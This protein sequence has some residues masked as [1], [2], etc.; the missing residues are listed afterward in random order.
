MD[1]SIL[2]IFNKADFNT[3]MLALAITGWILNH[4]Y[5][6]SIWFLGGAILCSI[7]CMI[8]LCVFIYKWVIAKRHIKKDEKY[9][10]EIREKNAQNQRLQAQYAYDRLSMEGKLLLSEIVRIG[11]KS[12]YSDVYIIRNKLEHYSLVSQLYHLRYSDNVIASWISVDDGQDS[13]CVNIRSPL[14][15]I[16]E[17]GLNN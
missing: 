2:N 15:L 12:C 9:K 3:L 7:Y 13:Y 4:Y 17:E 1:W 6:T 16:V 8:R 14:N 11:E 10:K 5:P